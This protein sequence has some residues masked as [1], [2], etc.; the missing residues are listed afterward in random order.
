MI[1]GYARVSAAD[2]NLD[3]Q[4]D[5]LVKYGCD[6][7]I[8]EKVTGVA[9]DKKL[10]DVVEMMKQGDTLV[11]IRMDRL[12]RSTRQ[13]IELAEAMDTQRK[14][15]VILNLN[16]DT[17]TPTGKFFLT[18]MA[19]FAELERTTNKEKQMRGIA[20]AKSKGKHLGRPRK[21][22]LEALNHAMQL[23][24]SKKYTVKE[25]CQ[26]T[27]ISKATFYRRLGQINQK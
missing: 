25:I 27:N 14:N 23:Y 17:R 12:G 22:N 2:Q 16:I 6:Q 19:A 15:L 21:F 11:A 7:I 26:I 18:I 20:L 13:L 8:T 9:E 3:T 1:Y 5:E 4:V 10:N 24:Q